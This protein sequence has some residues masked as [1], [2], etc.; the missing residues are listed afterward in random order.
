MAVAAG[1]DDLDNLKL[2]IKQ[3]AKIEIES[4]NGVTPLMSAAY[5]GSSK[6]FSFLM[7]KEPNINKLTKNGWS[8]LTYAATGAGDTSKTFDPS[9]MQQLIDAG[10]SAAIKDING[11]SII[12]LVKRETSFYERKK[13]KQMA[14]ERQKS[15]RGMNQ[16]AAAN[17]TAAIDNL[18]TPVSVSNRVEQINAILETSQNK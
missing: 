16:M 10:A 1:K 13:N 17:F 2:L 11:K 18:W 14:D 9:I 5:N 8:A 7:E 3:G 6:V 15:A 4:N 12:E